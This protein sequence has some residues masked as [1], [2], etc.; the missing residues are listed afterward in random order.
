MRLCKWKSGWRTVFPLLA[1]LLIS[2]C[3]SVSSTAVHRSA[4]PLET[5]RENR[6]FERIAPSPD[7]EI[8]LRSEG[9]LRLC[10]WTRAGRPERVWMLWSAAGRETIRFRPSGSVFAIR[11]AEGAMIRLEADRTGLTAAEL[12]RRPLYLIGSDNL[13]LQVVPSGERSS[14]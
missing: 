2:G 4:L 1:L 13:D 6:F 10:R 14:R 9:N 7:G 3:C 5:E 8:L 12:T 11:S